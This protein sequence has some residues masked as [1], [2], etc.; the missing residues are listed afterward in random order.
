MGA[1]ELQEMVEAEL[2]VELA[3][4]RL[5]LGPTLRELAAEIAALLVG[6][7]PT[8]AAPVRAR[9][10]LRDDAVLDPGLTFEPVPA[11]PPR[12]ML[13]TGATGFLGAFVLAELLAQTDAHIHCLVRAPTAAT[14]C[15][16]SRTRLTATICRRSGCGRG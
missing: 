10:S 9:P 7:R 11:A 12:T 6:E 8:V 16:A 3:T 1:L 4:D 15:V 5:L 14:A 2:E 13:L